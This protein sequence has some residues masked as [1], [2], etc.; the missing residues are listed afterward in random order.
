M[1]SNMT[2]YK[3]T[4]YVWD[5]DHWIIIEYPAHSDD[6][7]IHGK[8]DTREEAEEALKNLKH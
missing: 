6:Y 2:E 4:Q 8:Y 5:H 7:Y 3:I 1:E